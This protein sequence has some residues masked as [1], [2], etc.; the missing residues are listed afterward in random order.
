MPLEHDCGLRP[1]EHPV[2]CTY[3]LAEDIPHC[4]EIAGC[5]CRELTA[6]LYALGYWLRPV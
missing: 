4:R 5:L 6:Q 2:C 3:Q 1:D